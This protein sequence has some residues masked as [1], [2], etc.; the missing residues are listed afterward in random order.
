MSK[1]LNFGSLNIDHVYQ[2]EAFVR[3]GETISA[4]GYARHPGGKGLNQSIALA[5]AGTRVLHAGCIGVDGLF[6]KELL[7]RDGVDCS[8][9]TILDD[10]PTGHAVIQVSAQGENSIVICGGANQAIPSSLIEK[11][12][13]KLSPGD[14]VLLQNEIS[15]IPE[16]MRAASAACARIFFNPAPF[17]AAV[18]SYP[19]ELLDTLIVNE[20]EAEGLSRSGF[21]TNACNVLLT[22]G[23]RG[24]RY[25]P[26]GGGIPVEVAAVPVA[27]VVDTTA[28]GDTFI[29]YFL[30]D[31]SRNVDVATAMAE[32]AKAAS[33]CVAHAGAASSIPLRAQL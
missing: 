1:I 15:C 9:V 27:K 33:W 23:S 3:P 26:K 31:V 19:L 7:E 30:S 29:G 2:V 14:I 17:T 32:A 21:D 6:L 11:A 20:T 16:I 4:L 12:A 24:A 8:L 10:A 5:R 13:A 18:A 25:M 22:R 28:A